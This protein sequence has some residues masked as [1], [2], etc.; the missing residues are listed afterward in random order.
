MDEEDEEEEEGLYLQQVAADGCED[1]TG[2][3][4]PVR[5]KNRSVTRLTNTFIVKKQLNTVSV[6]MKVF[7][8]S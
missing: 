5:E 7:S 1:E 8:Y 2:D 4:H 6:F 3:D